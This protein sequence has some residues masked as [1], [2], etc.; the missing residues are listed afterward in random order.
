MF[1][2]IV[3]SLKVQGNYAGL[4]VACHDTPRFFAGGSEES[5]RGKA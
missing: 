4:L 5:R 3:E 2:M 1:N